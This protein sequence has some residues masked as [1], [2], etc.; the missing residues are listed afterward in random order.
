MNAIFKIIKRELGL[1]SKDS[2]LFLIILFAPILY[3]FMYGSVYINKGEKDVPLAV[4]DQD[5]SQMS[6]LLT[7]EI[8]ATEMVKVIQVLNIEDA[9]EK[10]YRGEV[11]GYFYIQQSFEKNILSQKQA[12]VNLVLNA[13]RFL[14]SSDLLSEVTKVCLTIGGGIRKTYFN[15]QGMSDAEAMKNTNP[16]NLDYRPLYNPSMTYGG[17][18]LP[19]LLA[20]ILQQ[21][22]LIGT[23][24][25]MTTEREDDSLMKVYHM[26]GSSISKIIFGKGL[27][28]LL[29]F[30]VFGIFFVIVN[31]SIF[32]IH[33]RGS[34]L[35]LLSL[36]S[37][38]TCSIISF[39]ML[40]GSFFKSKLLAFQ[41][42]VFSSYP[43]FLITGYSM[44]F[45]ALPSSVQ[46]ISNLL[47]TSPFLKVYLSIVEEGG[48]LFDNQISVMHL[49]LLWIF[50]TFLLFCRLKHV[51][52]QP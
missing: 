38:F 44:P 20:I 33:V 3:A 29:I 28:Y 10:M 16:I 34:F 30:L 40:L 41:V 23:A 17:F 48:S 19:G 45:Q 11:Q 27:I 8:D 1:L 46:F 37:I 2:S 26:G 50:Y 6:R 12:N 7:Y 4:I 9:Q 35:E 18:L 32:G 49:L 31:Y 24:A 39:G 14:P 22:L 36:F 52:S 5:G 42:L 47:P 25:A 13:S 51:L 43:I 21:T 15:K